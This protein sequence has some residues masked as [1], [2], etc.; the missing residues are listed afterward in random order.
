MQY[1]YSPHLQKTNSITSAGP[2]QAV[3][4][5]YQTYTDNAQQCEKYQT[6]LTILTIF[7]ANTHPDLLT[8]VTKN[9]TLP[10][11]GLTICTLFSELHLNEGC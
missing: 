5:S 11:T 7:M 8:R 3:R 4:R 2:G 1:K 10:N 6:N 9:A